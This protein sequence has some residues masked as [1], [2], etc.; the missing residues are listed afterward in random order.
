MFIKSRNCGAL[1]LGLAEY[2][3]YYLFSDQGKETICGFLIALS[4]IDSFNSF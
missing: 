4:I 2:I 3:D 1:L